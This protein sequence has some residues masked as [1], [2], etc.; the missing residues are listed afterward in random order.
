MGRRSPFEERHLQQASSGRARCSLV[1]RVQEL[2]LASVKDTSTL[3]APS[4]L[5]ARVRMRASEVTVPCRRRVRTWCSTARE[6]CRELAEGQLEQSHLIPASSTHLSLLLE[7][8]HLPQ[9]KDAGPRR[10]EMANDCPLHRRRVLQRGEPYAER[11]RCTR[12]R[13]LSSMIGLHPRQTR[14]A[15][16]QPS[17]EQ[18]AASH[19]C[20]R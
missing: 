13:Q 15:R 10:D 7:F 20:C 11:V 6:G 9:Q 2:T 8:S 4:T 5:E 16:G 12:R 14:L 1:Q 17:R 3:S 18:F 19:T